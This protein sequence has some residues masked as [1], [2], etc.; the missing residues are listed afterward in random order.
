VRAESG[1]AAGLA[2]LPAG[3][4]GISP[5]GDRFEP[6]LVRG[7]GSYAVPLHLPAGPNEQRPRLTL[8]YS[9]GS[10]NGPFGL[11]WRL[12]LP[13][14]ERRTDRGLPDYDDA[15]DTFVLGDA[16]ELVP[17]G[18]GRYR[19]RVDTANWWI[20]RDGDGW[21]I[22]T[23]DGGTLWLGRT[24]A[25]RESDGGRVFA[26]HLD[27]QTDPAGNTITYRYRAD[28][29]RLYLD[30][31]A[32]SVFR[33]RFGYELRPDVLRNGRAGYLRVM[34]LRAAAL[35][36]YC[37]R[38]GH[39]PLRTYRFAYRTAGSG[40]SLLTG[41][42]LT[43]EADGETA[44]FPALGFDYGDF[45]PTRWRIDA[46]RAPVAPP[47]AGRDAAQWVDLTGD[48]LPDVLSIAGTRVRCW[49]NRG[50]GWLDGPVVLPA[51]PAA[52]SLDRPTVAFA[53]LDGN[54]RVDLFTA[55]RRIAVAYPA[56]GRGGFAAEPVV[57][58]DRPDLRLADPSTR[59]TD[60]DGDG[61]VDLLATGRD[62]FL[63][64]RHRPGDGWQQPRAVARVRDLDRFPDVAFGER[65]VRLA[66]MTGDGLADLVVAR[67]G[68]CWYWP[69]LGEGRW[70]DRVEMAHPPMLPPGYRDDRLVLADLDGDGCADLAYLDHDR[71]VVW[72][73]RCG[74]GFAP[75][76]EVPV[77]P[78]PGVTAM[79]LDV[80][81]DGRPGLVWEAPPAGPDD[82][83]WRA[84]RF[85]PDAAVNL[86][87]TVDNGM[88]RRLTMTY[89]TS[90]AMRRADRDDGRDWPG[91]L[92]FAVWVVTGVEDAD[93]VTGA[94]S[95]MS[96]RYHDGVYDGP[97]REF[98]GF[99]R[100]DVDLDGDDSIP[101][102]RQQHTFFQGDPEH[103]DPAERDRQRALAGTPVLVRSY[104]GDRLTAETSQ[105][106]EV[107]GGPVWQ[108]RLR[109]VERRE[110][111][112]PDRV[113]RTTV[114]DYDAYGNATR[115]I[116][117][118][119]GAGE[120][121]S[122]EERAT[123][124]A[125]GPAWLVKAPVR[126]ERR[127]GSGVP[128]AV[129]VHHYDGPPHQGLPEGTATAGLLT[130]TTALVLRTA[131]LPA[132][133]AD[134]VDP[135]ALGY[136]VLGTG[137]TAGWYATTLSV[138]HDAFGNVVARDDPMGRRSLVDYD[139]DG[140][141]P[142]RAVDP[143][144]AVTTLVYDQRSGA[145]ARIERPDG[146]A[147]RFTVDP[148]GRM[149]ARFDLDDAGTEQLV[150]VWRAATDTVPTSVTTITPRRTGRRP[151]EFG[152]GVDPATLTGV[153]VSRVYF[154]GGGRPALTV[155]TAP[156]GPGGARRF[157][158]T[159]RVRRNPRGLVSVEYPPQLVPGLGFA[160]PPV[161]PPDDAPVRHR[162]DGRGALVAT[163]GRGPARFQ[164]EPG[165]FSLRHVEDNRLARVEHHDAA[166]RL[167]RI[168]EFADPATAVTTSYQLAADGRIEVL[169]DGTGAP[170]ARWMYAGPGDAVRISH[171][172]AGTRTYHRDAAGMIRRMVAADGGEL[173]YDY[174]GAGRLAHVRD[175]EGA[176]L[177]EY[178]Y[179][180]AGRLTDVT[181]PGCA[182]RTG[183]DRAGRAITET[184][185]TGGM[186]L[187]VRRRLAWQ[188]EPV[189]VIYPDGHEVGYHRDDAGAVRAVPGY[190]TDVSYDDEGE[191]DG[192]TFAS[193]VAVTRRRDPISRRL[194]E[195]SAGTLLRLSYRYD[196]IG[197][198]VGIDDGSTSR[199]YRYDGLHRLAGFE[200]RDGGPA[201]PVTAAGPYPVDAA[202]NLLALHEA[203]DVTL[204]YADPAHPGRLTGISGTGAVGY[205]SRGRIT[206]LGDL[207]GIEY[208]AFDRATAV[209]RADGTRVRY[210]HDHL[211]R[212]VLREVARDGE[213]TRTRYV[214]GV[215]EQRDDGVVRHVGL[216]STRVASDHLPTAGPVGRSFFLV[217]HHGTAVLRLDAAGAEVARQR[218]SAYGRA[219]GTA[220]GLDRFIG[221][222][223][224]PDVGLVPLGARLYAPA[225]GRFTSPDWYVLENPDKP[226]RLP[227]GYHLYSY[228]M[229]NPLRFDDPSGK[230]FFLP[231]VVGFVVGLAYG[232]ADGRGADGAWSL[233]KETSLTTG[234]GFN[235]GWATGAL[236]GPE[237]AGVFGVMGGVNGLFAGTRRIY[238]DIQFFGAEGT[239]SLIADSSW[240]ILGT[241]IGNFLNV[242]NLIAAPSSYRSDL[243]KG[244]NRQV[245]DRGFYLRGSS[246]FT[247]GNV[248][249]NLSK[250]KGSSGP[251]GGRLLHHESLH[252][253]QNRAFG[254]LFQ[255][256][257]VYWLYY[258]GI[259][260]AILAPFVK[261]DIRDAIEDVAYLDNPWEYWAY[262][263]GGTEK[264]HKLSYE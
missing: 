169:R 140:V 92:P 218:Y 105:T 156:D 165:T 259:V 94:I 215:F 120:L 70:G 25:S 138:R 18:G 227:Q 251:D 231:F 46:L 239:A 91:M 124:L 85:D 79:A 24:A 162:Y 159:G 14:V 246:A 139:A 44:A 15:T 173:R 95:R 200:V 98:R 28:G 132:G 256:T 185:D 83:G 264:G 47:V 195:I 191:L 193:G 188:G 99:A 104:A 258:G 196:N 5:L 257:Y 136:Q 53:D 114:A 103:P 207:S 237:A 26:W 51:V 56:D 4:G 22:R 93:V 84:L 137:D 38:T 55:D 127:D 117:Q 23:G 39:E 161:A 6:D 234:V 116:Q 48:G 126:R 71:T 129:E 108:P 122:V 198:I 106:W 217:D 102:S 194:L 163:A 59:L 45:D 222:D 224:D 164:Y 255:I 166:G 183:Y 43:A 143:L 121:I 260:G 263:H 96:I 8:S 110:P 172:D 69:N 261:E 144:G 62:A 253:F 148:L 226:A 88:G 119:S 249:S 49:R 111:G 77:A 131:A 9:T 182:L 225:I 211:G 232:Y 115:T 176:V 170:V 175:A 7:S 66:D 146:R 33:A 76:V 223:T 58:A 184:V 205:D 36:L 3:G 171:R 21:V 90:A 13:R 250:G 97:R 210:V 213:I 134:G 41:V 34:G 155:A 151:D 1:A 186:S 86:L 72:L 167:V 201:G 248:I 40:A 145:P 100:V 125:D 130:R 11:G 158:A 212:V 61:V 142:V 19:P 80:F 206:A 150:T 107:A 123:Y 64:Y 219:L 68:A 240:G 180:V 235:L 57:F 37:E 29:G 262:Q 135:A 113:E 42:T 35:D 75:P 149:T 112:E 168:E 197:N 154:D 203:G 179:D 187:T 236:F 199:S 228:G 157:L 67:G 238:D 82:A 245:Y 192:Y 147:H 89:G 63:L 81:G 10:G 153:S 31:I 60:V 202:G 247:Q 209:V 216:E 12:G 50:D 54:G 160:P 220:A 230:W 74:N 109:V 208:D 241:S 65:G 118:W 30:E 243:S 133:Y 189:A 101:S 141:Y 244:Q 229:N 87:T 78:R 177:R 181:E 174:D 16:E 252:I 27:T 178:G 221:H 242:Y 17:V 2:S 190:V 152:A 233:A 204:S 128:L 73:N 254:P 214:G 52:L 20:A 32:W